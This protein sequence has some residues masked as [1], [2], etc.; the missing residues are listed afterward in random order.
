MK[1]LCFKT[2]HANETFRIWR[3]AS[4]PLIIT[5]YLSGELFFLASVCSILSFMGG[6][7]NFLRF[8]TCWILIEQPPKASHGTQKK[9]TKMMPAISSLLP[10]GVPLLLLIFLLAVSPKTSASRFGLQA[11]SQP[12]KRSLSVLSL[13]LRLTILCFLREPHFTLFCKRAT[14]KTLCTIYQINYANDREFGNWNS[15]RPGLPCGRVWRCAIAA[16]GLPRPGRSRNRCRW[17]QTR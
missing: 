3:V 2:L 9:L 12:C 10:S 14:L 13:R 1:P 8:P 11:V 5:A 15:I 17:R 7:V 6:N 4:S 16:A